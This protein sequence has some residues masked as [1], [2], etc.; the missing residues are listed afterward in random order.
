MIRIIKG[1]IKVRGIKEITNN[2]K[3]AKT[4]IVMIINRVISLNEDNN[5][6]NGAQYLS[7]RVLRSASK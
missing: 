2:K 1:I 4:L 6:T 3:A 7:G 5:G